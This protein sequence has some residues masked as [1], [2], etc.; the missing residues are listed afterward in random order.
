MHERVRR[1]A[2]RGRRQVKRD[3]REGE[4][5]AR[6]KQKWHVSSGRVRE[7]RMMEGRGEKENELVF[8]VEERE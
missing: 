7:E 3:E 2:E 4:R 6:G 1:A 8:G 5:R